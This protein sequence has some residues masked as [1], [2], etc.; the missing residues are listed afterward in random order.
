[1][2]GEQAD[3]ILEHVLVMYRGLQELRRETRAATEEMRRANEERRVGRERAKRLR[4]AMA[5]CQA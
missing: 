1:M 3:E 5:E 2:T 4:G